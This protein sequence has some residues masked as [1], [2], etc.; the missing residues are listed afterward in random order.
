MGSAAFSWGDR[1]AFCTAQRNLAAMI[2]R[3]LE[4]NYFENRQRPTPQRIV[5][6]LRELRTAPLL[7]DVAASF[8]SRSAE[9]QTERPCSSSPCWEKQ[10]NL[11]P[12]LTSNRNKNRPSTASTGSRCEQSWRSSDANEPV[13]LKL[14]GGGPSTP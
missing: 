5:F 4:A 8:P 9:L 7:I 1:P 6:W 10:I 2:R 3:L 12:P 14:E 11:K 13:D